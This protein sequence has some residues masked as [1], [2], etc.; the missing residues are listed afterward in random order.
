MGQI[1]LNPYLNFQ[2]Q[3]KAAMEF[4][5]K[6]FG[7]EL[8]MQTYGESPMEAADEQKDLIMHAAIKSGSFDLM[9][10]DAPKDVT[11][12]DNVHL[13]LMGD[14]AAQLTKIFNELAKGGRVTMPLEKQ[15]WGDTFGML[16]D[17]FGMH[18]MININQAGA[19]QAKTDE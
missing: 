10:A 14:D 1:Q 6:V 19:E 11:V 18:W 13:S 15:F 16:T 4:Y 9:A 8:T 7:G 3:A 17:Q 2:G 12:G 5:K